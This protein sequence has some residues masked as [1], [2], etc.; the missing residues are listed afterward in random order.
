MGVARYPHIRQ[1][2]DCF[3]R[4]PGWDHSFSNQPPQYLAHLQIQEVRSM[5]GI[6]A[7]VNS[8]FNL[9]AHRC[10]KQPVNCGG[11]VERVGSFD[12]SWPDQAGSSLQAQG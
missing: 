9:P 3:L 11:G 7:R 4:A 12:F 6:V 2:L 5:Q 1:I 10:L 8:F